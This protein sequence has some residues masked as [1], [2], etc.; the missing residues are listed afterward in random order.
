M[1]YLENLSI[2]GGNCGFDLTFPLR[3]HEDNTVLKKITLGFNSSIFNNPSL[4]GKELIYPQNIERLTALELIDNTRFL[5]GSEGGNLFD[6]FYTM[7]YSKIYNETDNTKEGFI[8][9][10][11]ST[12][13]QSLT[14]LVSG[15]IHPSFRIQ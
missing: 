12:Y 11:N 10:S 8:I 7:F 15:F 4:N 5:R 2:G 9:S 6:K 1:P 3:D 13:F 14:T